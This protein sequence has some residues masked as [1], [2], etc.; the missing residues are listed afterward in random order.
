MLIIAMA[1]PNVRGQIMMEDTIKLSTNDPTKHVNEEI[2]NDFSDVMNGFTFM[3][4][5]MFI[6]FFAMVII[7]FLA[8]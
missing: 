3:F 5:F 8:S 7:K 1:E 4:G 2:R 6:V